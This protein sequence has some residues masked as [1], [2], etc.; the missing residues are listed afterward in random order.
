MCLVL[1]KLKKLFNYHFCFY[2]TLY[3]LSDYQVTWADYWALKTHW[4]QQNKL[5]AIYRTKVVALF[6]SWNFSEQIRIRFY[7]GFLFN[8]FSQNFSCIFQLHR[9][10][11]WCKQP[12]LSIHDLGCV[13]SPWL[14]RWI[15]GL[16][17]QESKCIWHRY[18]PWISIFFLTNTHYI[19][20]FK[21]HFTQFIII[22]IFTG[23]VHLKQDGV[24]YSM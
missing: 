17:E 1:H 11:I 10:A 2:F 24:P 14:V 6:C 3:K 23:A 13:A 20:D 15:T 16:D 7:V 21:V 5:V 19:W 12:T 4:E 18:R 22:L 9:E 8:H